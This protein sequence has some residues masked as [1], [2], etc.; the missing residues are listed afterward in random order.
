MICLKNITYIFLVCCFAFTLKAGEGLTEVYDFGNNPA[1][2]RMYLYK[3][4]CGECTEPMDLVVVLHGCGQSATEIAALTGWNKLAEKHHFMV[5]YPQQRMINNAWK[6]FN[7]YYDFEINKGQGE[8]ESI[9]QMIAYTCQNYNI[10]KNRIFIT[11]VS[12]GAA[13]SVVMAATHPE[14]FNAAAVFGGA[15]YKAAIGPLD[16]LLD[17]IP[18]KRYSQY[19][20][21]KKVEEQNNFYKTFYC[22]MIIYQGKRDKIVNPKNAQL[23]IKQWTGLHEIDTI[24]DV[25]EPSFKSHAEITRKEYHNSLGKAMVIFYEVEYLGHQ[26]MVKP[27]TKEDEG[28]KTGLFAVDRGFHSTYQT[29]IDFGIIPEDSFPK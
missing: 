12:A 17:I 15:A 3:N 13:M 7:W 22:K 9:Y 25:V 1:G 16:G 26:L 10:N 14:L 4:K 11:G 5:L 23:L 18:E 19:E 29:A 6:C 24:A 21:V 20:L 27:G 2:L 8:C 28:G